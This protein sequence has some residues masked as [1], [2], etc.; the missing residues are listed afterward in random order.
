MQLRTTDDG[1]RTLFDPASGET[2]HSMRGAKTEAEHVFLRGSGVQLRLEQRLPTRVL[3]VGFGAGLNFLVTAAS[4]RSRG[5]PLEYV[6][7]DLR[8]PR[9][10]S[11]R[12]LRYGPAVADPDLGDALVT[13]AEGLQDVGTGGTHAFRLGDVRLELILVDAATAPLPT[14]CQAVYH[15]AFSP[16]VEPLLWTEAF[17]TD[18]YRA[19]A[20]AGV[21][22]TY[23]VNGALRRRLAAIG[24]EVR[25]VA[26]PEGGKRECLVARKPASGQACERATPR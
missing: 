11:L 18:L 21:L 19:M 16:N 22:A 17:L 25:K 6:G 2:Y 23:S 10:A 8:L 4:A 14:A 13:W 7:L 15:D 1:S 12:S 24:F 20:P 9:S 26:G 5:A 3:E